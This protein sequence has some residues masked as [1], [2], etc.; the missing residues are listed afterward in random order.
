MAQTNLKP[1]RDRDHQTVGRV[2]STRVLETLQHTFGYTSFRPLQHD[3][4]RS[5]LDGRDVFVLMPTG[6]GKSLCYQLPA[7]LTDG[8]TVVI[9]PLI[10]LMKDQVDALQAS[11]VA[12]TFI[13]SALDAAEIRRR[14]ALVARGE[15]KLLYVAPER[16]ATP[17][18]VRLLEAANP[19]FFAI[20]EAHCISEWGHDFRPEYRQLRQL[21]QLFPQAVIGAFTA[22]A[23]TR[24]QADIK[25]QLALEDAASFQGSFNRANL[26]YEVR[27]KQAAYEQIIDYINAHRDESGIIYCSTRATTDQVAER[28]RADGVNAASYHAGLAGNE[29]ARRPE[30]FVSDD[31]QVMVATIAF[32]MGIDKPDVRFVI[33]HDLPKNLEGF[34]QESGRAGRDGEAAECVLFYSYADVSKHMHFIEQKYSEV[35]RRV[36]TQQLQTMADWAGTIR[37]RRRSML[38]YF[39]E[40]YDG[41][42]DPCCD[43][44][45]APVEEVEYTVA[46]QMF[47]S[48]VKRTGERFGAAH[49]ID[50]LR[51]SRG[52]KLLQWRHDQLS[53]YGIGKER[54]KEEWQHVARQLLLGG[55][56]AQDPERYNAIVITERGYR[57]LFKGEQVLIAEPPKLVKR[58]SS[59]RETTTSNLELFERLRQL[60]KRVADQRG[61]PPYVIL[62]DSALRLMTADLPATRDALL[63]IPGIGQRKAEEFGDIFLTEIASFTR[64]HPPAPR[65][66][67][68]TATIRATLQLFHDGHDLDTIAVTRGMTL[69]TVES[70]IVEALEL[71]EQLDIDRL[72]EPARRAAIEAAF[73]ELG[74]APLK[75]V[76][77]L[78]G[79]D[80]TYAELRLVR[81]A[82]QRD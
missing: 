61:V 41:S 11:G 43:V 15:I 75:P 22:T 16:L 3:I 52:Q 49:V 74:P 8:L 40:E 48:C 63:R 66:P 29:R 25:Q 68:V 37:C 60:R 21:R 58:A 33:H 14:Q 81:A 79:G 73:A 56:C 62:H 44:C 31:I 36:A 50:V 65:Q 10:A 67:A 53:T 5:V 71:G 51:G 39:D 72:I 13:N 57:V 42:T 28:L 78:L 70:H 20:D 4:V 18:F 12:A 69:E 27:P 54:S 6:G 64:A 30:E 80:Y 17:G 23:T 35:E 1:A 26:F 24:V 55:F 9:S 38:A 45:R 7:L 2:P 19:W 59:A 76:L 47:L 82:S 46:A 32:G 77:E 34:Y